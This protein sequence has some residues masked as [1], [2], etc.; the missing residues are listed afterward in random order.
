MKLYKIISETLVQQFPGWISVNGTVY[1]NAAAERLAI[2][3]GEWFPLRI[4]PT[5][6]YD[7]ETEYIVKRYSLVGDTIV[8]DWEVI[9]PTGGEDAE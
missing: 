3:S 2:E 8:C 5:P 6:V 4:N 9:H 1:T 7:P